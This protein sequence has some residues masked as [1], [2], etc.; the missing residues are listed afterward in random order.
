[1]RLWR[2]NNSRFLAD[3]STEGTLQTGYWLAAALLIVIATAIVAGDRVSTPSSHESR[4]PVI[5]ELFSSEGCSSCPPAD[6]L[7][8]KLDRSQ[9]VPAAA[10]IVLSE[11]VDYWNHIGWAD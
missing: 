2:R 3:V 8:E 7:L 6:Q 9:P 4:T 11:H 5:V 1:M 10:I